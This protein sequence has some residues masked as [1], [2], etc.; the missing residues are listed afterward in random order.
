[1]QSNISYQA[2]DVLRYMCTYLQ[3]ST[4]I[5]L[6]QVSQVF[7]NLICDYVPI[8]FKIT[9]LDM[10][11]QL[12]KQFKSV[13]LELYSV[14]NPIYDS[15]SIVRPASYQPDW[16][17]DVN[18]RWLSILGKHITKLS[19]WYNTSVTDQGLRHTPNLKS[20]FL[21]GSSLITDEGLKHVPDITNLEL[22]YNT[23][24]RDDHL[25]YVPNL[26][27]LSLVGNSMITG[28]GFR[29]VPKL[30]IL[31]LRYNS[32]VPDDLLIKNPKISLLNIY[33]NKVITDNGVLG[34]SS[35]KTLYI[36]PRAKISNLCLDELTNRSIEVYN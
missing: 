21:G 6:L 33:G 15:I 10:G 30:Q 14:H 32:I 18:D 12:I 22:W 29:F 5:Q 7:K 16:I 23:S 2:R 26:T 11:V 31:D 34:L 9:K 1:M 27:S 3:N 24:I 19:M 28:H 35:L 8:R 36:W 17:E 25:E 20:L 4:L 13:E